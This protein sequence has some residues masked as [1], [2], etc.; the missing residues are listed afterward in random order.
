MLSVRGGEKVGLLK[1]RLYRPFSVD[2]FDRGSA[3][4]GQG[5]CGSGSNERTGQ[6][7]RAALSGRGYGV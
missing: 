3:A 7:R 4:F 5:D 1:V 2:A 6:H